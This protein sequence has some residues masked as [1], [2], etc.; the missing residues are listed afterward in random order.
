MS[1]TARLWKGV[2]PWTLG[3]IMLAGGGA[4]LADESPSLAKQLAGLGRQAASQGKPDAARSFYENALKLDPSNAEARKALAKDSRALRVAYQ[5]P[6]QLPETGEPIAP[7]PGLSEPSALERQAQIADVARQQFVADVRTRMQAARGLTLARNPEAALATLRDALVVVQSADNIPDAARAALANEVRN[8]I[9]ATERLEERVT[10]EKAEA[11]RVVAAQA[12][13]TSAVNRLLDNQNTTGTLMAEFDSLMAEGAYRVLASGGMG[14]IDTTR[15]PFVQ[16]R[17]RAQAARA[18]NPLDLAPWAGMFVSDTVGFYSQSIQYDRLKEYRAMLTWADVDRTSVPFPDSRTI[19]YPEKSAWQSLSERRLARYSDSDYL[20]DQDN[21]TKAILKKL[22]EPISMN[23]PTDTP[24]EDVKKYIQTSTQDE[25][26]GLPT[27]IPIYV[28]PQ[29][30]QD[31]DKTEASTIKIELEGIPLK[32]TLRLILSQLS[33]TYTVKDGLMTITSTA[34]DDQ[35]TEIRV[36]YAADLALIPLSLISGGGGGGGGMGG[37]G[38]G[39]GGM[40][41]GGMGGGGGGMGGGMGGG[42]MGGGGG[43]MGGMMSVPPQ[44]PG[45]LPGTPST[46]EEK[47]SN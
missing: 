6:A 11:Y 28:D 38:M 19:E 20:F 10:L 42:G 24:L 13:R 12:A 1:R 34:S 43:M 40:G 14:D 5:D 45:S 33:L 44:D 37:G 32:T 27:G 16:A 47:K 29:G 30:L 46:F 39:G 8:S 41:G 9:A 15:E 17:F 26:A 2:G 3:G 25:A 35:P 22:G 18:L 36:Y 31:A 21:K 23:F 4:A 7:V